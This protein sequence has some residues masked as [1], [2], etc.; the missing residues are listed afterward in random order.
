[1]ILPRGINE[2]ASAGISV[3]TRLDDGSI[4]AQLTIQLDGDA[5]H[6]VSSRFLADAA[7]QARHAR[8]IDQTVARWRRARWLAG[9]TVTILSA[10]GFAALLAAHPTWQGLGVSI[11]APLAIRWVTQLAANRAIAALVHRAS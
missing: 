5:I 6:R 11:V 10:A 4:G 1:M 9:R 8:A 2:L 7:A 3:V